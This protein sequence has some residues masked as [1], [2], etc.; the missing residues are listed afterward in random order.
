MSFQRHL[1][2]RKFQFERFRISISGQKK[3][4]LKFRALFAKALR[5]FEVQKSQDNHLN[6]S[7]FKLDIQILGPNS[8]DFIFSTI[9]KEMKRMLSLEKHLKLEISFKFWEINFE[10][11]N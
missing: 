10:K 6:S 9:A 3:I 11:P 1:I 2:D 5:N 7:K 8:K 4:F